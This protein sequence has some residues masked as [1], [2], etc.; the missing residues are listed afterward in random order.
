[1]IGRCKR[2]AA[3]KADSSSW[4]LLPKSSTVA[5]GT[6]RVILTEADQTAIS[7]LWVYGDERPGIGQ[8][9]SVDSALSAGRHQAQ[10]WRIVSG[11]PYLIFAIKL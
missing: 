5:K 1:V 2:R 10:V 8:V 9:I 11:E 3:I 4:G 7:G 6:V